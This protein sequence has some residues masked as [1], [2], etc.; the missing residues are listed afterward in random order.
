MGIDDPYEHP[1]SLE[2]NLDIVDKKA[3][4]NVQILETALA[5]YG[6][7]KNSASRIAGLKRRISLRQKDC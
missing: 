2:V 5:T 1:K 4:E 6:F 7:L 3:E